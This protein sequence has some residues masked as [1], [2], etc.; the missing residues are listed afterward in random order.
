MGGRQGGKCGCQM[1]KKLTLYL[2]WSIFCIKFVKEYPQICFEGT[3]L[4]DKNLNNINKNYTLYEE[5]FTTFCIYCND[6][7]RLYRRWS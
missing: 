3:A 2:Y 5:T 1:V 4:I 6:A 7:G